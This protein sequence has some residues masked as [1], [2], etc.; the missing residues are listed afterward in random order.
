MEC[1]FI[2]HLDVELNAKIGLN[3]ELST[4]KTDFPF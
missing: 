2:F 4:L 3:M 1:C